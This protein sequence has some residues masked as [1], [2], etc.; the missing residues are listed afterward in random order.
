MSFRGRII[1]AAAVAFAVAVV[2]ASALAFLG[3]R[4]ALRNEVDAGLRAR[5]E[6]FRAHLSG[7]AESGP[8]EADLISQ[9]WFIAVREHV[10]LA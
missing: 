4:A 1:L 3:V 6:W 9:S 10:V 7:P 5:V 2:T 8:A